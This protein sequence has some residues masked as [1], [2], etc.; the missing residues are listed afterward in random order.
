[1]DIK[2]TSFL[3]RWITF[4]HNHSNSFY[5]FHWSGV[6]NAARDINAC[7]PMSACT[8]SFCILCPGE[9]F[10]ITARLDL[11]LPLRRIYLCHRC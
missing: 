6:L 2:V 5:H 8:A 9:E 1:M 3:T 10:S 11:F 4:T 7:S